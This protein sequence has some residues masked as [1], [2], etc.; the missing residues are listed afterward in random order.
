MLYRVSPKIV[1][2]LFSFVFSGR[3]TRRVINAERLLLFKSTI[4][5]NNLSSDKKHNFINGRLIFSYQHLHKPNNDKQL[6]DCYLVLYVLTDHI[7][8]TLPMMVFRT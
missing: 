6:S 2:S 3:L 8:L 7:V 1:V 4:R 5:L